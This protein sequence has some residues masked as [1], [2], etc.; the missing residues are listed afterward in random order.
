VN[1]EWSNPQRRP[2][3][4]D[5]DMD[6]LRFGRQ[7]RALRIRLEQRQSD[8]SVDSG[9][10]RSLIAAI[11]R[12][13]IEGVTVGSLVRAARA[14][15]ADVDVRLRWRGE[16]LDR[17]LDEAHS[18][19]V[20]ATVTRLARLGWLVEVEVSFAIWGERGSID[21]LAFH[22]AFGA[23]LVI[24]VKSVVADTQA[25][26]HGLDRKARLARDVTKSR[27][28]NVRHVSRLLVVGASATSRR[29]IE[30]V[31]GIYDAALP[32]RGATVRRWLAR[33]EEALA[34]VLFLA[35]AS[36]RGTRR[37]SLGRERVRPSRK[38]RTAPFRDQKSAPPPNEPRSTPAHSDPVDTVDLAVE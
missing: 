38:A 14:L 5:T 4:H 31:A 15:G 32:A 3:V 17:L 7:F 19:V 24:E 9:L 23:L 20:D 26:L 30:R 25:T 36:Q 28:W 22:P 1:G 12:G 11:D 35:N 2:A 29:R 18:A 37:G 8:V 6:A 27:H 34:G 21:V 13:E 16:Q 10:S 33:P